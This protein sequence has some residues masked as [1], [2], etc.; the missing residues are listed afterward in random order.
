MYV[1]MDGLLISGLDVIDGIGSEASFCTSFIQ[2]V[3]RRTMP[4]IYTVDG[5]GITYSVDEATVSSFLSL[6]GGMGVYPDMT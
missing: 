1:T 3:I 2:A 4:W 6:R 5:E